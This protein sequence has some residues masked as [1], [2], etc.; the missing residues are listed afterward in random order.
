MIKITNGRMTLSVTRGS[1][2]STYQRQGYHPVEED[3]TVSESS[4]GIYPI[5]SE[6][7]DLADSTQQEIGEEPEG[8]EPEEE[9]KLEEIPLSEMDYYQLSAYADQL[10]V[11]RTGLRSTK[12][13]RRVIRAALKGE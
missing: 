13:L 8:E 12:D 3:S 4:S 7:L 10:G 11:D 5:E 6:N 1:F 2:K 9:R